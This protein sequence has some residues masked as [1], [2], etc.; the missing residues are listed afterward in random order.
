M[1]TPMMEPRSAAM[2]AAGRWTRGR[3]ASRRRR[4]GAAPPPTAARL[5][6]SGAAA[7]SALPGALRRACALA[8]I[9]LAGCAFPEA[10]APELV[11]EVEE[12]PNVSA[13]VARD[14]AGE[15]L[16]LACRDAGD[17]LAVRARRLSPEE[18]ASVLTLRTLEAVYPLNA[19]AADPGIVAEGDIP[20]PLLT[21]LLSGGGFSL[22]YGAQ[23]LGPVVVPDEDAVRF[24]SACFAAI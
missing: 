14:G 13:L 21:Y 6:A 15:V 22:L 12:A 2:T 19:R 3:P 24:S 7:R 17:G 5:T 10:Y 1:R 20:P 11:W 23:E 8:A 4:L 9:G 18:G 16:R